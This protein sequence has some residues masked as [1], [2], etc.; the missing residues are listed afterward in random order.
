[1]KISEAWLREWVSPDKNAQEIADQITMAGLEVDSIEPV[2][3]E[4]SG[5]VVGE[6]MS[7]EQ[8]PDADK[9]RVCQVA[10]NG[11]DT[12]QVVCGAPNAR[13][14]IKI[15]FATVGAKLPGDEDGKSFKIKKAKLRGVESFG[16]LC[17]AVELKAGEDDS[18]LWEL[19]S[20]AP[21]SEDLQS[22]L[23]LNDTVIEV[24][25]TPNRGDCLSVRGIARE[26]GVLNQLSLSPPSIEPVS[27][28]IDDEFAVELNAPQACPKYVGR[29]IRDLNVK[30]PSPLWLQERLRRAG[31]RSIDCVVDMTNYLLLELGVPMHAFDLDK[32]Q[33]KIVVRESKAKEKIDLLD[34]QTV[35]LNPGTLVI[36][37]DSGPIAMAGIMGG[38]STAVSEETKNIFFESAFFEPTAIAGKARSYGLHTDSS[39]RFE[40]GV[41]YQMQ[42]QAIER[43]SRLLIEIAGGKPGPV[44]VHQTEEH[45]PTAAKVSLRKQRII[46][47]LGAE[48][49]DDTITQI[50]TG[51]GLDI[52]NSDDKG[53]T[54]T[55]PSYRFDI[56]IEEDLLEEIARIYGYNNLPTNHLGG[57]IDINVQSETKLSL[58]RLK[59]ILVDRQY[60]E[61][62]TYSFVSEE[63][64]QVFSPDAEAIKLANPL[65]ADLAIMRGSLWSGL[66][67]ALSY[68]INRQQGRIRLFEAGM[69]FQ[70]SGVDIIQQAMLA[71]L[72]FGSRHDETWAAKEQ[73]VDFFDIK[74]D[75][76][77]LLT[78]SGQPGQFSFEPSSHPALHPGQSAVIM[79]KG[80]SVGW[81]G[82]LHP[83][84]QQQLDLPQSVY[85]FELQ[86]DALLGSTVPEFSEIS[87]FP[88]V[89]RDIAVL[90][91]R[92]V[93]VGSL[94]STAQKLGGEY[95]QHLKVFDLYL[96][97]G[98][99]NHRKSVGLGLT[100]QHPSRTL[101]E[102][103]INASIESVVAG[104]KED[105]GADLR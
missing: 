58:A 100:F 102:S 66:I 31:L 77:A 11:S 78:A 42:E 37:D 94:V 101:N 104:L 85:L 4:F 48:I 82:A 56:T 14:G 72:I 26:V 38:S 71:G 74:G 3:G 75:V 10:G 80:V 73:P 90:V 18:G 24:D 64:N 46:S 2:S 97:K 52:V 93:G 13:V 87:K 41:D 76:E 15:P 98:I 55:V 99:E 54:F 44:V 19:P 86:Q 40:R 105:F 61:A 36:T 32:L 62:I 70:Q 21:T 27:K 22:Y 16:M 57:S 69:R 53:W 81:V 79:R 96:G 9:L 28:Q 68:N 47:G 51:I 89:R 12:V 50:L 6:I 33:G 60:H 39:H 30:A 84:I 20:D 17:S 92:E 59:N 1:M 25:L 49:P 67:Q 34:G 35:E 91:D 45:M 65:S 5:V 23:K 7:V 103:E 95:L 63:L 88:E 43:A 8:H 83:Q 29:V